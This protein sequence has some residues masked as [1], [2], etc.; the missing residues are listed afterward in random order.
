MEEEPKDQVPPPNPLLKR[1][2]LN[3]GNTF[4]NY[5]TPEEPIEISDPL[6]EYPLLL[7]FFGA[8]WVRRAFICSVT[9]AAHSWKSSSGFTTK[10]I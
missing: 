8:D 7:I 1:I 10:S 5:L 2:P 3:L 6:L 9:S 4:H